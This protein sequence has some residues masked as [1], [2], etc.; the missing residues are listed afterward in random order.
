MRIL[1]IGGSGQIGTA[2]MN[3]FGHVNC[4][5]TYCNSNHKDGMIH[6]DMEYADNEGYTEYIFE[7]IN[8]THV[9]ICTGFTWV[10]G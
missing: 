6:F 10:D 7:L 1:V 5:G 3:E 2:I 8:P 9:F 4:T